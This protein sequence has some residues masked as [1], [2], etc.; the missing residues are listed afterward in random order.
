MQLLIIALFLFI[1]IHRVAMN[2]TPAWASTDLSPSK[3]G[4]GIVFC[5]YHPQGTQMELILPP[6]P[7]PYG[8]FIFSMF[9]V[10]GL[11]PWSWDWILSHGGQPPEAIRCV[12]FDRINM[13]S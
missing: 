13:I 4:F 12:I 9:Q 2:P 8:S 1:L 6:H 5:S 10:A 7:S 3:Q 11:P